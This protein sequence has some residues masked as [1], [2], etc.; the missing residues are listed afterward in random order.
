MKITE[1]TRPVDIRDAR[2]ILAR[3]GY[4]QL[5]SGVYGTVFAKENEP[6]VLKLFD[7]QDTAYLQFLKLILR[8]HDPHFPVVKGK[9]IRVNDRYWAVRLE[10]LEP[11][12]GSNTE[13]HRFISRYLASYQKLASLESNYYEKTIASSPNRI[14]KDDHE[15]LKQLGDIPDDWKQIRMPPDDRFISSMINAQRQKLLP[16]EQHYPELADALRLIDKYVLHGERA[17]LHHENVMQ[18]GSILV[19]TDPSAGG[20]EGDLT[21]QK[22]SPQPQLFQQ[23]PSSWNQKLQQYNYSNL[24]N[25]LPEMEPPTAL[26]WQDKERQYGM[27]V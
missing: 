11:I 6:F 3:Y 8:V 1:I 27:S 23:K 24:S 4:G 26:G 14:T 13:L 19:I 10:R 21:F 25:R 9:P 5:G 12:E 20:S 2:S 15:L 18:R 17:D 16:F 22:T 7:D